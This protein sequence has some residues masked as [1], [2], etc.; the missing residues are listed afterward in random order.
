MLCLLGYG[1]SP[2]AECEYNVKLKNACGRGRGHVVG[3]RGGLV[4]AWSYFRHVIEAWLPAQAFQNT[5]P[6]QRVYSVLFKVKGSA[7]A[8]VCACVFD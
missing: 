1:L 8:R 7:C 2:T 5:V 4:G 6:I 3:A